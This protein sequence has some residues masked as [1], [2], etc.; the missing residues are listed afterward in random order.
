[1]SKI[2]FYLPLV[3]ANIGALALS[4]CGGTDP[5]SPSTTTSMTTTPPTAATSTFVVTALVSNTAAGVVDNLPADTVAAGDSATF[6]FP[7]TVNA[8]LDPNL[9]HGWGVAFGPGS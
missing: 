1:M 4:A 5:S 3:A 2:R 6:T 9:S 7:Q 8:T